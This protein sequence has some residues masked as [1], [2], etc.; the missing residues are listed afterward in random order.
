MKKY[1]F[2]FAIITMCIFSCES[3][4][5]TTSVAEYYDYEVQFVRTGTEGTELFKVFSYGNNERE[6]IE[7][8]KLNAI[9]AIFFKGIP[10]SG[11]QKPMITEIGVEEKYKNYFNEFLKP[12][13]KYLNY[14]ALS[15]DGAIDA[16]DRLKVGKRLKIGIV[17]SVQ[18]ANLRKELEAANIIRGLSSGF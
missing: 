2:A 4:K 7:S 9:K 10:G 1:L 12:G 5:Q 16:R 13:G 11:L 8:A 17:V 6:C 3:T 18:K 15:S 14:V